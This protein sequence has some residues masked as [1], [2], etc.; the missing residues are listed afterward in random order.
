[1]NILVKYNE[2]LERRCT[3]LEKEN[4]QL[5]RAITEF[6]WLIQTIKNLKIIGEIINEKKSICNF[7]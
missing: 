7:R 4:E 3:K 5:K 1:M 6:E 2:Q